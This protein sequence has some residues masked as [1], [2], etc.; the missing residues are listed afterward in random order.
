MTKR[1]LEQLTDLKREIGEIEQN[2]A[3]IEQMDIKAVPIKVDASSK[4]FPYIQSRAV[5]QEYDPVLADKRDRIL[6]EKSML[7]EERKRKAAEEELMLTQYINNVKVSRVRR[8]MQYR[9]V[10]GF[11]WEKIGEIMHCDRTTAEKMITRYLK[12]NSND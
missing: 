11:T 1:E 10:E 5:V 8:I 2:I 12:K 4:C 7:L 9:Y 6:Y 3:K